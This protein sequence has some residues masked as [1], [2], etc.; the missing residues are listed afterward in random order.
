MEAFLTD[1]QIPKEESKNDN[2]LK[3]FIRKK[4][5]CIM[6]FLL[7]FI[8][9]IELMNVILSKLD[10]SDVNTIT[11]KIRDIFERKNKTIT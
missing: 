3:R 7:S 6:I 8:A 4:F 5:R 11:R 2:I 9:V 1:T 10:E